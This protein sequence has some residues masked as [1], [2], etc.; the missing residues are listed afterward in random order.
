MDSQWLKAQF[1]AH[2]GKS[3]AGL[4]ATLGLEP[5]AISKILNGARQIKA[6][7]YHGMRQYFG[8]P[9]DGQKAV[10]GNGY[11]IPP[12]TL[13]QSF[14][15]FR[16][17]RDSDWVIPADILHARTRTPPEK[18][19][20]FEVRERVMEPDFRQGEFVIVDLSD[21]APS[22]PGIFIISDGFGHMVRHCSYVPKSSPAKIRV[23]AAHASFETQTLQ[24]HEFE[25][26][27]RVIARL[28][29]L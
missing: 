10:S 29:W 26:T 8:L 5:P 11:V 21:R 6:Q 15:E 22:P 9:T 3:K 18:I 25:I 20:I 7:E 23:A 14:Q 27:G 28:H 24:E 12:L 4:A 17:K 13:E 19:R 1:K 16:E 2:P